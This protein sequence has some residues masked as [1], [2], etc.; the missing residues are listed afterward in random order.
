MLA[1]LVGE[2]LAGQF[3]VQA[4]EWGS[5]LRAATERHDAAV[6]EEIK[7]QA[8][9]LADKL[10]KEDPEN[11]LSFAEFAPK[12]TQKAMQV[13]KTSRLSLKDLLDKLSSTQQAEL[14]HEWEIISL[15]KHQSFKWGLAKF[16]GQ[17]SIR[18]LTQEGQKLRAALKDIWD[19]SSKHPE[20]L[21]YLGKEMACEVEE[22]L[23]LD[24][25]KTGK[26]SPKDKG[27]DS[28][29]AA[30]PPRKRLKR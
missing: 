20:F 19:V 21:K 6:F 5:A 30:G 24:S 1:W 27:K 16:M 25:T 15:A 22:V 23:S 9:A 28:E 26:A 14:A 10:V 7:K 18:F 2:D 8:A 13:V 3:M 29:E 4:V 12:Q 11:R 17:A